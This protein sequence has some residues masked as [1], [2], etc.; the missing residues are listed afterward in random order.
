MRTILNKIIF[1]GL[2]I[3]LSWKGLDGLI[4]NIFYNS[5]D[6]IDITQLEKS[7]NIDVR[8]IEII[9]GISYKEDFIYYESNQFSPIDIIYPILS[10]DQTEKYY[11]S[12]PINI[13]VLVRLNNQKRTCLTNGNCI[14][15]DSTSLKGLVKVGLENLRDADFE[16][17]ESDLVKLDDNFILLE[18]NEEPIIWYWNLIM[19]LV[20]TVFGFAILKSFFKRASSIDEY[21][22]IITEKNES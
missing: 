19:F 17:L 3:F 6:T 9:N 8:N 16:T 15:S 5:T 14:P 2:F 12:E 20:G 7:D 13:K 10:H 18:P 1:G 11:N 22:K 21:W 4:I